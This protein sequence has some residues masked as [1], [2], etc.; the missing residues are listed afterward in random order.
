[1]ASHRNRLVRRCALNPQCRRP[2][3]RLWRLHGRGLHPRPTGGH[4]PPRY[5]LNGQQWHPSLLLTSGEGVWGHA[6]MS[7][8]NATRAPCPVLRQCVSRSR[9]TPTR[10]RRVAQW[11]NPTR[12]PLRALLSRYLAAAGRYERRQARPRCRRHRLG[13]HAPLVGVGVRKAVGRA[14]PPQDG[15]VGGYV[16]LPSGGWCLLAVHLLRSR[17]CKKE[18]PQ[19]RMNPQQYLSDPAR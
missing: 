10:P 16:C 4:G 3:R 5:G 1:M 6:P 15:P 17:R 7:T 19:T 11:H 9:S 2:A 14:G 18:K 8:P 12:R 13:G